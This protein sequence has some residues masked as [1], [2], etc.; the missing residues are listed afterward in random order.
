[1]SNSP[2][3]PDEEHISESQ[4]DTDDEL[5]V[6]EDVVTPMAAAMQWSSRITT[7]TIEMI[8]PGILGSWLDKRWG[9]SYLAFLGFAVGVPLGIWH[10]IKITQPKQK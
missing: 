8:L 5:S 2:K 3:L 6:E 7:I 9:T 1:M 10:L 4:T